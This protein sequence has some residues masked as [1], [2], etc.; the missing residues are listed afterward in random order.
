MPES[1]NPIVTLTTDFGGSDHY[2][3]AVKA[4]ILSIATQVT[5]VDITH[6][7][8]AHDVREA[9]W[10]LR[11]AYNVFP[12][13]TV[14]VAVVDP[15]VGTARRPIVAVT[16]SY[17][18]V[19]PDNGIFSFVFEAEPPARVVAITAPHYLRPSISATFHA[20]DVFGPVA[21][22]LSRGIDI[23]NFGETI[24]DVTRLELPRPKVMQDGS[25]RAAVAHVDRF[26]NVI[27]NLSR[28]AMEAL[29]ERVK[30]SVLSATAGGRR[31]TALHATYGEAPPGTPFLLYN[32]S[33]F[34]EIAVNQ[35]RASDLLA[36]RAGD[37]VDLS[38][39]Q[40]AA[41]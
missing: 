16:E 7:I 5:I 17:Y 29:M 18:F 28:P 13:F 9:A 26:G 31:I 3:G 1:R 21:A 32:S 35:G 6:D 30:A 2:V 41:Q 39:A 27:L 19:G 8:P 10:V 40:Q 22:H 14:H 34:L 37:I 12:K 38:L 11:N 20:R 36:L 4:A 15:G 23:T 25:V 33:D 24:E